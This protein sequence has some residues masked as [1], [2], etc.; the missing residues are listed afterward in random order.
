M[1]RL[2]FI[3][4]II[5]S[6]CIAIEESFD[7]NII[8]EKSKGKT[9]SSP[10]KPKPRHTIKDKIG[11]TTRLTSKVKVLTIPRKTVKNVRNLPIK[12]IN[13]IFKGKSGEAFHKNKDEVKDRTSGLKRNILGTSSIIKETKKS[14]TNPG[15]SKINDCERM[16]PQELC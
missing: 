3:I 4:L 2:F 1:K 15:E 11:V 12:R 8:L 9:I 10:I 14:Y 6:G 5:L 13:G 16:F 7:D